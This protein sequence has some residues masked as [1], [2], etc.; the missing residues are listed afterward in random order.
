LSAARDK[1]GA[2]AVKFICHDLTPAFSHWRAVR[3][4][5]F[6]A[7]LV[8]EHIADL[9]GFLANWAGSAIR[10]FHRDFVNHPA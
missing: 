7:C 10:G 6:S 5:V 9:K 2:D 4:I 1:P 8:L 3:S